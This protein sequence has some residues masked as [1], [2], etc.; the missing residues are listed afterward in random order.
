MVVKERGEGWGR[1]REE[2]GRCDTYEWLIAFDADFVYIGGIPT[3]KVTETSSHLRLSRCKV[4]GITIS[5]IVGTS[6]YSS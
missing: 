1:E 5:Y 6:L 4:C 2:A 3:N